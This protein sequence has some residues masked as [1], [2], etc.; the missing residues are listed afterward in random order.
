MLA[1]FFASDVQSEP[2]LSLLLIGSI[3]FFG[4][5]YLIRN[6][7]RKPQK[8]ERFRLMRKLMGSSEPPGDKADKEDKAEEI[9]TEKDI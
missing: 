9:G 2:R 7:R 1:L 4:G 6:N 5:I 3:S 8:S